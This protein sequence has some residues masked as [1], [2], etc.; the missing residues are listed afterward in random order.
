LAK[1]VNIDKKQQNDVI[2]V[3]LNI[4]TTMFLKLRVSCC[5]LILKCKQELIII[6]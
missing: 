3:G 6:N 4:R 2:L 1:L 5:A